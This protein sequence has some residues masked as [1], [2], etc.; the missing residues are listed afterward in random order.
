MKASIVV[1]D[2]DIKQAIVNY[3]Y[4]QTGITMAADSVSIK[5]KSKNN[6]HQQDWE[7]GE[8]RCEFVA[9]VKKT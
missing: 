3:V 5:V 9:P 7:P 8:L 2:E 6:Y 1:N 4:E